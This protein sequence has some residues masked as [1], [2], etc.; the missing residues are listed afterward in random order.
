MSW[1]SSYSI[2]FCSQIK[3]YAFFTSS[4]WVMWSQYHHHHHQQQQQHHHRHHHHHN[5]TWWSK[6]TINYGI[7]PIVLLLNLQTSN[8]LITMLF[9]ILILCPSLKWQI[10]FQMHINIRSNCNVIYSISIQVS[11]IYNH[12]VR[13]QYYIQYFIPYILYRKQKDT[14]LLAKWQKANSRPYWNKEVLVEA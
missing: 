8:I 14:R 13:L 1:Y 7:F 4:I 9:N 6:E 10:K 3:F 5:N 12:Q 2:L 11:N